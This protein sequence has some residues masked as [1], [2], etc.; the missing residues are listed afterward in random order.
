[1]DKSKLK[2]Y[3]NIVKICA[4]LLCVL[5][6]TLPLV[7]CTRDSSKNA[8]CWEIATGTGDLFREKDSGY[9]FAFLLII[10]PVIILAAAFANKSF[11]ILRNIS[12][13]GLLAKIIFLI[14]ASSIINSDNYKGAFELT[15]YN[16]LVLF[17]YIGLCGFTFYCAKNELITEPEKDTEPI[18]DTNSPEI[19]TEAET[20]E[21]ATD[22]PISSPEIIP[23]IPSPV[24][25]V[26]ESIAEEPVIKAA[27]SIKAADNTASSTAVSGRNA[28]KVKKQ[29]I[30]TSTIA[31]IVIPIAAILVAGIVVFLLL[32]QKDTDIQI[33]SPPV[34]VEQN[35]PQLL[36]E[37]EPQLPP[38]PSTPPISIKIAPSLPDPDTN[39]VYKLQVGSFPT[40]DN[41][42]LALGVRL[43]SAGFT[44][45]VEYATVRGINY[46]RILIPDVPA[47]D[48]S[49][50]V[51]RLE[52][53]GIEEVWIR[54]D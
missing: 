37:P 47:P 29:K 5:F 52:A 11:G 40:G 44:P 46:D 35:E 19:I 38:T 25:V 28:A 22:V 2:N 20:I 27:D 30:K 23:D 41:E 9:P 10:I 42:A 4:L 7:Q 14:Y 31:I 50:T 26:E 48:V 8:S 15:G 1:M 16:W 21:K 33:N 32:R 18:Q 36:P 17:I 54:E 53:I 13:G 43:R 34:V 3:R 49:R 39:K 45:V 24:P 51:R 6:F 12:I